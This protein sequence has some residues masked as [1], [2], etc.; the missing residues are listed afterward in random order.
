[1]NSLNVLFSLTRQS[2][3]DLPVVV[4]H[5]RSNLIG[6]TVFLNEH[7]A[8]EFILEREEAE[9]LD[10]D[11]EIQGSNSY[12]IWYIGTSAKLDTALGK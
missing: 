2:E 7:E 8:E 10:P 11:Y 9:R 12:E 3:G 5:W 6:C 4:T 1:M